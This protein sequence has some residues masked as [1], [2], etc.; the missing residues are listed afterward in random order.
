MKRYIKINYYCIMFFFLYDELKDDKQ[1]CYY[2][3]SNV[4]DLQD[5]EIKFLFKILKIKDVNASKCDMKEGTYK[6]VGFYMHYQSPWC[7]NVLSIFKKNGIKSIDRIERTTLIRNKIFDE[8]RIDPMLHKIYKTHL[9]TFDIKVDAVKNSIIDVDHLENFSK[10]HNL[11]FDDDDIAYYKNLFKN[12]MCRWPSTMEIFDLAQ[13]N[14]EHSR[15]WFF[16]GIMNNGYVRETRTLMDYI[17]EPLKVH[18]NN[19]LIA[20]CDNASAIDSRGYVRDLIPKYPGNSSPYEIKH[21]KYC[22]TLNAET[23][24]FPTGISPFPGAATGVGGRIR[25]THAIGRGGIISAGLAGYCVGNLFMNDDHEWELTDRTYQKINGCKMLLEASD[26]AS[27]YGNKFGEPLIGG[28]CRSFGM[29][30]R[31]TY[32]ENYQSNMCVDYYEYIKPIM[33]SA[34]IGKIPYEALH[35]KDGEKGMF[36]YKIGGPA[37]RIGL[38]GGSASSRPQDESINDMNAVQRGDPEMENRMNRFVRACTEMLHRNPIVKIHDQGA[39]GMANVTKEIIEPHGASINIDNVILGDKTM[40]PF[41]IWNAEYQEQ[42]TILIEEKDVDLV[43]KIANRENVPIAYIGKLNN[44]DRII[45]EDN[46]GRQHVNLKLS[47][48]LNNYR[49]KTYDIKKRE[50]IFPELLLPSKKEQIVSFPQDLRKIFSLVSVGSKSFLTQKVDRTVGGL[51]VQQQCLGPLDL[52]LSNYSVVKHSFFSELATI[53]GIGEQPIKGII[54]PVAMV[55][56]SIGE[57]LTNM[58]WG[59]IDD[60]DYIKCSGNWMWPNVDSYEHYLLYD[61]V[62]EVSKI[63]IEL[64]IAIDGGKDSLSMVTKTKDRMIKSP[65]SFVITGYAEMPDH[66]DRV[67]VDLKHSGNK[68]LYL[69]LSNERFRIGGSAYAQTRNILG[70]HFQIPR[71]EDRHGF[72]LV[73]KEVQRLIK[74]GFII[75]GHDVSDGG[76]ITT[77]C[78]MCFAGNL[79]CNLDI[80]SYVSLYEFMFSE[81]LGLVIEIQ[82]EYEKYIFECFTNLIPIYSLG[83]ITNRNNINI[84]YNKDIVLN[85]LVTELR[86]AWE[87]TSIQLMEKQ[88]GSLYATE[89]REKIRSFDH[90]NDV[91]VY[92]MKNYVKPFKRPNV[93]ILRDEGTTGDR[94]MAAAFFTAG[95]RPWDVTKEEYNEMYKKIGFEVTAICGGFTYSDVLGGGVGLKTGLELKGLQLGICNGCQMELEMEVNTSG[96]LE[97]DM[98]WVSGETGEFYNIKGQHKCITVNKKG[99]VTEKNATIWT[100]KK[101]VGKE[102]SGKG[103]FLMPHIERMITHEINESGWIQIF[104]NLHNHL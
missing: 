65:R 52:P 33:Y 57:M 89:Y 30:V 99:R 102:I 31:C 68:L 29:D 53:S 23:H 95:F 62:K 75:S 11:A 49:R 32:V 8:S 69:N 91:F 3:N 86:D 93:A 39:G 14:S 87:S 54:D 90:R 82:P 55:G 1:H 98:V 2:I 9:N 41:E 25:D 64:G 40:T 22:P 35:K 61:S 84:V 58:I 63:L 76:L 12:N 27:D 92:N 15:H 60:I 78:E 71:F 77:V 19:S 17:K 59:V 104:L 6:E 96:R 97:S 36:I 81:E 51:V 73:F 37:F 44:N 43:M 100:P 88:F 101:I 79:G 21:I 16:N 80:T 94:E 4:K 42:S 18:K 7:S 72:V 13:C 45:V 38:G 26:G 48:I 74:E 83:T 28:F 5:H 67:T 34:G 24:N 85:E 66:H 20:F 103:L 10:E 46:K 47:D 56:L 50:T 70:N